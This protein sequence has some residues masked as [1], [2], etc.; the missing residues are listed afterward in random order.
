MTTICMTVWNTFLND[1]RVLKEAQ[2]LSAS[3]YRVTVIAVHVKSQTERQ[4]ELPGGI[5]VLRVEKSLPLF[6]SPLHGLYRRL[7]PHRQVMHASGGGRQGSPRK[8]LRIATRIGAAMAILRMAYAAWRENADIYHA[9]DA[10][11]L[12]MGWTAARLRGAKLVYDAHEIST[13]RE[14]YGF[15]RHVMRWLERWLTPR[16]EAMITTTD[17]RADHF[18]E[19]YGCRRP[20]VLQNRPR[21]APPPGRGALRA[22][23]NLPPDRFLA[24]YQGGVQPGRG[25]RN[26]VRLAARVPEATFVFIGDGRQAPELRALVKELGVEERVHFVPTIPLAELP[27]YTVDADVGLQVLRNTCLNHWTTDSN[28]L[29]EYIMAGVPVIASDFPE[30]RRV[31]SDGPVGILVDPEDLSGMEAAVRKMMTDEP[32][33]RLCRENCRARAEKWSWEAQE[34]ELVALYRGLG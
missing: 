4:E 24:L 8:G 5:R 28:K 1:A 7:F 26:I 12:L 6:L 3:G 9:H 29:F 27:R 30:I 15:L 16:V 17:L 34:G 18:V 19:A 23:L 21:F 22:R 14:G 33:R 2:T 13:D 11:T 31:V 20:L 10:N 25:L 32:F